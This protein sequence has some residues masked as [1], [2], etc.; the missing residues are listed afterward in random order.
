MSFTQILV[1][2]EI[3]VE[4]VELHLEVDMK[5]CMVDIINMKVNFKEVDENFRGKGSHGGRDGI[6]LGQQSN[7]DSN[8]Y[9]YKCHNPWAR[10]QGKGLQR[11]GPRVKP[12]SHI[13]CS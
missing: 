8:C 3:K 4:V 9:Y 7:N 13:S 10:D 11:C 1:K 2:M 12:R 5:A 6:H